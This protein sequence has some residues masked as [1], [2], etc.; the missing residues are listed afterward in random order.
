MTED[1][2][3]RRSLA[4]A[5]L[6]VVVAAGVVLLGGLPGVVVAACLLAAW[7]ALP[8]PFAFAVGAAGL[9][10]V[11]ST[12]G[13]VPLAAGALGLLGMLALRT[14]STSRVR[15][16]TGTLFGT[17]VLAALTVALERAG[18]SPLALA[19]AL[20]LLVALTAYGVHRYERVR[21]DHV[22]TQ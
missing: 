19:S 15:T 9:P 14:R 21:L 2:T 7:Y 5:G 10:L 6:A 4:S 20:C 13:A 1:E 16:A 11:A 22:S 3:P 18:W 17:G 8:A 12:A